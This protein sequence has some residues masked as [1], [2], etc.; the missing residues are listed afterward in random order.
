MF[1]ATSHKIHTVI[2]QTLPNA[3]QFTQFIQDLLANPASSP[4]KDDLNHCLTNIPPPL[5]SA[6]C[7]SN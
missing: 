2:S 5:N 7:D 3:E 6:L 4:V 1:S